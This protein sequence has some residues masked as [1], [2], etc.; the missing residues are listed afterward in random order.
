MATEEERR[1]KKLQE[2]MARQRAIDAQDIKAVIDALLA[3]AN[4]RTF[5]WRL[6]EIGKVGLTPPPIDPLKMAFACGEL[7]VGNQIMALLMEINPEGFVVMQ[8]EKALAR[9]NLYSNLDSPGVDGHPGGFD[10]PGS[11][12]DTTDDD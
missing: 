12:L 2:R 5:C 7:N 1:E 9:T 6:L 4:G 3:N 11:T 8:K 10:A